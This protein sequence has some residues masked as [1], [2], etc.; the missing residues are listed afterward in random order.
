MSIKHTVLASALNQLLKHQPA[1]LE[2]LQPQAG[3]A[4]RVQASAFPFQ[5]QFLINAQGLLVADNAASADVTIC[6]HGTLPRLPL[7]PEQL[8]SDVEISGNADLAEALQKAFRRIEFNAG[9][10]LQPMLGDVLSQRLAHAASCLPALAE[11][12]LPK[13]GQLAACAPKPPAFVREQLNEVA[14]LAE[15]A[16]QKLAT[17]LK[18]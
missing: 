17:L 11:R 18:R 5:F 12:V 9:D 14:W 8:L 2:V 1:A 6:Y 15:Q 4:V 13:A 7:S 16:K 10:W 3:K